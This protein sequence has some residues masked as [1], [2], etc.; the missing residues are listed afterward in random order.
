MTVVSFGEGRQ[1]L[2]KIFFFF[3][4]VTGTRYQPPCKPGVSLRELRNS[5]V[6]PSLAMLS[7]IPTL[8]PILGCPYWIHIV[9][10]QYAQV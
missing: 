2:K 3:L 10:N 8:V 4:V 5:L 6:G 9:T 1:N 7:L